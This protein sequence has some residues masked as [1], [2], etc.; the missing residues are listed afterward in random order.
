M[1]TRYVNTASTA[2]GDGTTNDTVGANRAYASLSGAEADLRTLNAA[3]DLQIMCCGTAADTTTVSFGNYTYVEAAYTVYVRSNRTVESGYH[4]GKWNE[5]AYRLQPSSSCIFAI[6][7]NPCNV[8][9]DGIQAYSNLSGNQI[10][11]TG[12]S[13]KDVILK[14]CIVKLGSTPTCVFSN[15]GY[16]GSGIYKF[17]NC[18]CSGTNNDYDIFHYVGTVN[19]Y[20]C[21]VRGFSNGVVRFNT[22]TITAKNCA[23]FDNSD[24]FYGAVTAD[25]CASDDGDGT[26]PISVSS[27]S[28][29]FLQ[30][31][32]ATSLDFRLK[33]ASVLKG[34]GIGPD[35]DVETP[36]T[37]MG[38]AYRFGTTT[39]AGP[40]A[41]SSYKAKSVFSGMS[42][43]S[44]I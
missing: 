26:N 5:G 1:V 28:A 31:D 16:S 6:A 11:C 12:S 15:F 30:S 44:G 33:P 19:V 43:Q 36:T 18:V 27:W 2:G 23:V 24:D 39:D 35:S 32:Y 25:R 34:K 9:F 42:S 37:S 10:Q 3:E 41:Y 38:S 7:N 21:V 8:V 20:N 40:F 14:E 17:R 13:S 4:R 22:G 29:Q